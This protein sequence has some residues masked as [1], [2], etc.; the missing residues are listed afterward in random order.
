MDIKCLA[1]VVL[2]GSGRGHTPPASAPS[3]APIVP[4]RRGAV[5]SPGGPIGNHRGVRLRQRGLPAR[6]RCQTIN[7]VS[8]TD[9]KAFVEAPVTGAA[10]LDTASIAAEIYTR[11]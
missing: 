8:P 2:E 9:G 4:P 7:G 3:T 11:I 1:R 10:D 5:R 6:A